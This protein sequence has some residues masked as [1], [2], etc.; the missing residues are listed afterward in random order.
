MPM[1]FP[2]KRFNFKEENVD[3]REV[4]NDDDE[5]PMSS[6]W[7]EATDEENIYHTPPQ[8]R[9]P[10]LS[11]NATAAETVPALET[12]GGVVYTSW[13]E[14]G[15]ENKKNVPKHA[16]N[17]TS[18]IYKKKVAHCP[19]SIFKL[20]CGPDY[21]TNRNK[22]QSK[23]A[24]YNCRCVDMY[25]TKR[26]LPHITRFLDLSKL[27]LDEKEDVLAGDVINGLPRFFV[28]TYNIP[29]YAPS[30]PLYSSPVTDGPGYTVV[31]YFVLSKRGL[32]ESKKQ[33]GA[34]K[35]LRRF[36]SLDPD[37]P[38]RKRGLNLWK[39]IVRVAN[40]KELG[41]NYFLTQYIKRYN[42]KP[43]LSRTSDMH[44]F[45]GKNYYEVNLDIHLYNYVGLRF[46]HQMSD[47]LST[48]VCEL[49]FVV[50]SEKDDE[51]PETILGCCRVSCV[52]L[53]E[54]GIRVDWDKYDYEWKHKITKEEKVKGEDAELKILGG[55][56]R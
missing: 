46:M 12:K 5:T 44:K 3:L 9:T 51:M 23:L 36:C 19:G 49:G 16:P 53:N 56:T 38:D 22:T 8:S 34:C 55:G 32:E 40:A 28:V 33:S 7:S 41:L 50:Q 27:Q 6:L 48:L 43:W 11:P 35:V 13:P 45:K 4:F 24:L 1:C 42:A 18:G 21:A 37:I 20:R 54:D 31:V 14:T 30:M 29:S 2:K 10:N 39:N 47:F 17:Q 52:S 25:E 15:W 26:K